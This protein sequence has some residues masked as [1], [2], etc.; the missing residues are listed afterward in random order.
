MQLKKS[1]L[2]LTGLVA[3][4]AL[5]FSLATP[6]MANEAVK[7][8]SKAETFQAPEDLS[9]V[10]PVLLCRYYHQ[11]TPEEQQRF[12]DRVDTLGLLSHRDYEM[13]SEGKVVVGSSL[14][15]MYM[16]KGEPIFEDGV[17]IRPMVFKVVHVY[18]D[19][20]IVT[21]SGM[22]MEVHERIE[23]E[24]P[25]SL[26]QDAPEVAPPPVAPRTR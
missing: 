20:Y 13:M 17:Q 21:Q 12:Y 19:E 24:L 1:W 10:R 8:E 15:G 9:T 25:P 23:G 5:A 16:T 14:C 6:V 7:T 4:G 26:R 11:Q 22:V 2:A 3:T 18:D